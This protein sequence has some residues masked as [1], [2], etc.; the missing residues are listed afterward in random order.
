MILGDNTW[1][2]ILKYI[3]HKNNADTYNLWIIVA[4]SSALEHFKVD[5]IRSWVCEKDKP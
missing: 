2:K 1:L 4:H 5:K 3:E